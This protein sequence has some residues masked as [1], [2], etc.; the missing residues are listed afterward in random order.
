MFHA[1]ALRS[2]QTD[3][4]RLDAIAHLLAGYGATGQQ[5]ADA[6][7]VSIHEAYERL[8]LLKAAVLVKRAGY[9]AGARYRHASAHTTG[10]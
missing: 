9:G 5:C 7:G 4:A 2:A 6:W 8:A 3:R 10:V 1:R